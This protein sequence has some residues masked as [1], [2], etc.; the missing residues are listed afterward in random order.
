MKKTYFPW[1]D[2]SFSDCAPPSVPRN[3]LLFLGSS[4]NVSPPL[5]MTIKILLKRLLILTRSDL[6]AGLFNLQPWWD[7]KEA[8]KPQ[9][10][11]HRKMSPW[12]NFYF[13]VRE[14]TIKLSYERKLQLVLLEQVKA[15]SHCLWLNGG[16]HTVFWPMMV[17]IRYF[18]HLLHSRKTLIEENDFWRSCSLKRID[19]MR[20]A[21][22]RTHTE[23]LTGQCDTNLQ[24]YVLTNVRQKFIGFMYRWSKLETK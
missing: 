4:W 5:T 13:W 22:K 23:D 3:S 7:F 1:P 10:I 24:S 18:D 20:A 11:L 16:Q 2:L 15:T 14:E 6:C 17:E 8:Q 19:T 21:V 12:P 9:Y